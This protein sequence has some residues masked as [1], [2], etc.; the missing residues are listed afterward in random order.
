MTD[1]STKTPQT[2]L[3]PTR[4]EALKA[5][6]VGSAALYLGCDDEPQPPL[7]PEEGGE[8]SPE[9]AYPESEWGEVPDPEQPSEAFPFGVASGD[10][11]PESVVLWTC[12]EGL[13]EPTALSWRLSTR[14]DLGDVVAEGQTEALAERGGCVKLLVEGLEPAQRYYYGFARGDERSHVG[15]TL[16][17]ADPSLS[18][19]DPSVI[20]AVSCASFNSGFFHVYRAIAED[21]DIELV[22]HL[23]DYI[24]ESGRY[25]REVVRDY[26]DPEEAKTLQ[27]YRARY[28]DHRR[29]PDLQALHRAHPMIAV[30]DDHEFAN[31]ACPSRGGDEE[32]EATGEPWEARKA[33]AERAYHEWL[34]TAVEVGEPL[35]RTFQL[36]P[37]AELWMLDT[38]MDARAAPFTADSAPRLERFSEERRLISEAQERWLTEGLSASERPWKLI[39]QQVMMAQLQVR[40]APEEE[41]ESAVSLNLDQWDGFAGQRARLLRHIQEEQIGGVVVLTG[42][43]HTSWASELS[44]NPSDPSL[45][46]PEASE[47]G[48]EGDLTAD[49]HGGAIALECVTPSVSSF[50]LSGTN[51]NLDS[52]LAMANPHIKWRELTRRGFLK[53]TISAEELRAEWWHVGDVLN[54][55]P[56]PV[57]LGG[58][59]RAIPTSPRWEVISS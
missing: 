13:E 38:R 21:E 34:P 7:E 59:T 51:D 41:R 50:A 14:P 48:G 43:I 18:E 6:A 56:S 49:P 27:G 9:P 55:T 42:D 23:G 24:Y 54:P 32:A 10:P 33:A 31:N 20:A 52:L 1:K 8:V 2:E 53:L 4:R 45:Y 39:G 3:Q 47:V 26:S 40:G 37:H 29:D 46:T 16:T 36:S 28:A 17:L 57:E 11:R 5:L 22:L 30:W 19:A 35:Y 25:A 44:L 12:L 58:A 15:R